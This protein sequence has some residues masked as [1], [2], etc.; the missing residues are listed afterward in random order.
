MSSMVYIAYHKTGI[1]QFYCYDWGLAETTGVCHGNDVI[2]YYGTIVRN[3]YYAALF[4][5]QTQF[6]LTPP[7]SFSTTERSFVQL[8]SWEKRERS[9]VKNRQGLLIKKQRENFV[10]VCSLFRCFL[11]SFS[12]GLMDEC[13]SSSECYNYVLT[14]IRLTTLLWNIFHIKKHLYRPTGIASIPCCIGQM[15]FL[16]SPAQRTE[17][18]I[19][20]CP[21]SDP[22]P[23]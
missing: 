5:Q 14:Y 11:F 23:R 16:C 2:Q 22:V 20:S 8:L 18:K 9:V 6:L 10:C 12:N 19:L 3:M 17:C 1:F 15:S 4:G 7:A 21:T 13:F